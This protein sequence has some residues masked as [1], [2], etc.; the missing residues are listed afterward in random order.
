MMRITRVYYLFVAMSVVND[1]F[2][3]C[4]NRQTLYV[5]KFVNIVCKIM[6]GWEKFII[7]DR[8]SD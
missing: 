6:N 7:A 5:S 3:R 1:A 2:G 4:A 8:K